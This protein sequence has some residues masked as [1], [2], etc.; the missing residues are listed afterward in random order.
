LIDRADPRLRYPTEVET[1]MGL[2]MLGFVPHLRMGR[3]GV[4]ATEEE[5][6]EAFEGLRGIRLGITNAYGARPIV[7]AVTSPGIGDGKTFM[8]S[9]LAVAF[10]TSGLRTL[11]IDADL[12]RG[13]VHRRLGVRRRPGLTEYLRGE[14]ARDEVIQG[15]SVPSLWVVGAGQ[16]TREAPELLESDPMRRLLEHVRTVFDVVICDCPPLGAG[17]DA[18]VLGTLTGNQILV[19]RAGV[20]HRMVARACLEALSR[21]P[22]RILGAVLN[23]VPADTAYGY[24]FYPYAPNYLGPADDGPRKEKRRRAPPLIG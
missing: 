8:S 9:N 19:L 3:S 11:L 17:V 1:G 10:A 6:A 20:S 18:Y 5:A 22:V 23:D 2:P 24:Y 12:R 21:L 13:M 4:A 15:T 14:A 16:H 7:F